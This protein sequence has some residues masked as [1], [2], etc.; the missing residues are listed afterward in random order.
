MGMPSVK[1]QD[2]G[3]GSKS[4]GV[5]ASGLGAFAATVGSAVGLGNIWKFPSMTGNNGGAAFVVAYLGFVVLMGIPIMVAE[6][7][8]GRKTRK[9]AVHAYGTVVPGKKGWSVF[10]WVG[11]VAAFLV[12]AFYTD[13]AGWV[14]AYIG[15]SV[16]VAIQGGTLDRRDF[17]SVSQGTWFPLLCQA[18][19]IALTT[20][21]LAA[22]VSKG[23][24]RTT[25]ILMPVLFVLLLA[26]AVRSLA[27]PGALQGVKYLFAFDVA[28]LTAPV[29]LSAMGLAFFKLSLGM[30]AMTT[31]GSY[32]PYNVRLFPNAVRVALADTF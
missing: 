10:G 3:V 11:C 17:E 16:R 28:K 6:H 25:K 2:R 15:K 22:G 27:L 1:N 18:G 29:L 19:V 24:E 21:V 8:I 7:A 23:I 13:V 14:F 20:G 9:N 30:G 26:C 32:L 5:F 31:Y 12:M 4:R